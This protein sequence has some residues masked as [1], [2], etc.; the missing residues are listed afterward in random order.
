MTSTLA[1]LL[2]VLLLPCILLLYITEEPKT[3]AKRMVSNGHKHKAIA[4]RLNVSHQ[5]ISAWCRA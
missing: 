5:Q 1:V 3:K 2:V 4:Q